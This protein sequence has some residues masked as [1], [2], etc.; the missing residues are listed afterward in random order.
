MT[1][2][3]YLKTER[4]FSTFIRDPRVKESFDAVKDSE[5]ELIQETAAR[6]ALEGKLQTSRHGNDSDTK[7]TK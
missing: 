3:A 1:G 7:K 5:N 6:M 2:I 4:R